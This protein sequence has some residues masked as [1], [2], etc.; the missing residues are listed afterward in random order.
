[1]LVFCYPAD[2]AEE[3][4]LQASQGEQYEN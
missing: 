3:A 1:M 4:E 2:P